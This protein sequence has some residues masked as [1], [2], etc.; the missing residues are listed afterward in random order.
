MKLKIRFVKFEQSLSMQILEMDDRFRADGPLNEFRSSTGFIIGSFNGPEIHPKEF[1]ISLRGRYRHCDLSVVTAEFDDNEK[2][3]RFHYD[4]VQALNEWADYC[5]Y[6][7][8][9]LPIAGYAIENE[10][11]KYGVDTILKL[12]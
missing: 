3:D 10:P 12:I 4:V 11:N 7:R 9:E 1:S 2:R 5:P 6:L 8:D